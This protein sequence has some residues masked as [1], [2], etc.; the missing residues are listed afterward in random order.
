MFSHIP[1]P[2]TAVNQ[3]VVH[4]ALNLDCV[5]QLCYGC[6][7]KALWDAGRKA[8]CLFL[9]DQQTCAAQRVATYVSGDVLNVLTCFRAVCSEGAGNGVCHQLQDGKVQIAPGDLQ[10]LRKR[11]HFPGTAPGQCAKDTR[12]ALYASCKSSPRHSPGSCRPPQ[13]S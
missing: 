11:F 7:L 10:T 4:P 12:G 8:V 9:I 13:L 3:V 6:V 1:L 5:N 2:G